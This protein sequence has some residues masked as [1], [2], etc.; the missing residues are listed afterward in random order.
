MLIEKIE[1]PALTYLKVEMK[2]LSKV[3]FWFLLEKC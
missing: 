1:K 3:L 2:F